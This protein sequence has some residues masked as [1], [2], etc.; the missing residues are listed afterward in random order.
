MR[1]G[2]MRKTTLYLALLRYYYNIFWRTSSMNTTKRL[3]SLLLV[4][5]LTFTMVIISVGCNGQETDDK[6]NGK[7]EPPAPTIKSIEASIN[8][9]ELPVG[10]SIESYAHMITVVGTYSD[11]TAEKPH[12]ETIKDFT[13]ETKG[14][15]AAGA[16]EITVKS[17]SLN[18]DVAYT[19]VEATDPALFQFD[20]T[21][22]AITAFVPFLKVTKVDEEGKEYLDYPDEE[23]PTTIVIPS[24]I[25]GVKVTAIDSKAFSPE[26]Q[27]TKFSKIII[28]D[29]VTT[30]G[31]LAFACASI[32]KLDEDAPD[33]G[34]DRYKA[35]GGLDSVVIPNSVKELGEKAFMECGSLVNIVLPHSITAIYDRTFDACYS[36]KSIVIPD[37]VRSLGD[38]AFR[39]CYNLTSVTL[40]SSIDTI[41]RET[42]RYCE[43]LESLVIPEGVRSIGEQA[44]V[45][46]TLLMKITF[47]KSLIEVGKDAFN[48]TCKWRYNQKE[49]LVYA[50]NV[51]IGFNHKTKIEK[52][53]R[54]I[55]VEVD[56]I[57][58][59]LTVDIKE[60][61]VGIGG[62]AFEGLE[63]ITSATI[64]SSVKYIG[65]RAFANCTGI[66]TVALPEN[67]NIA[68]S[69]FINCSSLENITIP[70][71]TTGLG[72]FAFDGTAWY[73]KQPKG[74]VFIGKFLY[75]Y[76]PE[77]D[78][79]DIVLPD[80]L[81]TFPGYLFNGKKNITSIVIPD[82]VT[83]IPANA[84]FNCSSLKSVKTGNGVQVI[85][86]SAFGNCTSLKEITIGTGVKTIGTSSFSECRNVET[87]VLPEGIVTISDRAF[88]GCARLAINIPAS[89]TELG[90]G[91]FENCIYI[92]NSKNKISV[93]AGTVGETYV[94]ENKLPHTTVT[95]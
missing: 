46:C 74:L 77:D 70:E 29:S 73:D 40:S 72:K 75:A 81:T 55:D 32:V 45:D 44:F 59:K 5:A 56:I 3:L 50:G 34:Y 4:L 37:T 35:N 60:G 91:V 20:S 51:V 12:K 25:E 61:T 11:S 15:V 69:A 13:L 88:F 33:T 21:T 2:F 92:E 94:K 79:T 80:G 24:S 36:L 57:P 90:E 8:V 41:G 76:T 89:V 19:G 62:S 84:F 43:V 67:I 95:Q 47:P 31:S 17:G 63:Q 49:G 28:P 23:Y 82:S 22:G 26:A 27:I 78:V 48:K 52:N 64:P 58:D 18:A 10:S 93:I 6:G 83:S 38:Y 71:S 39:K 30:I 14:A 53:D 87:L 16:G 7:I 68:E 86:D 54:D 42:F 85:E 66:T 9:A 65:N 1:V